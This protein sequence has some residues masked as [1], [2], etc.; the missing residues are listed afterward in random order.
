MMAHRKATSFLRV[1]IAECRRVLLT[2]G[3]LT[4]YPVFFLVS[5]GVGAGLELSIRANGANTF[6]MLEACSVAEMAMCAFA[7]LSC[8]YTMARVGRDYTDG[9]MQFISAYLGDCPQPWVLL[10][11]QPRYWDTMGMPE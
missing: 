4:A 3:T 7:A 11:W 8:L 1:L 6:G 5:I 10:Q 9:S 2:R